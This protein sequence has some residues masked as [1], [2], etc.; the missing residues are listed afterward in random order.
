MANISQQFIYD[1]RRYV[2]IKHNASDDE[3]VDLIE[4]ARADLKLGGIIASKAES[5][6]DA[7]IRRAV[8]LY[9]KGEFGLDNSE[10]E[11]YQ[12]SYQMLKKH[13]QLSDEY[14]KEA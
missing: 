2:R 9:V 10:A 1:A 6:S 7:L 4:A 8:F 12:N 5:E 11:K 13:L 3:I 14:T